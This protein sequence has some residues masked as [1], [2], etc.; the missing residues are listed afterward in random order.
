MYAC[1]YE[2]HIIIIQPLQMTIYELSF[3]SLGIIPESKSRHISEL[4]LN[5]QHKFI[6]FYFKIQ[7]EK[8]AEKLISCLVEYNVYHGP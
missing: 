5:R 3:H 6:H 8:P 7:I 1:A 2:D 4:G